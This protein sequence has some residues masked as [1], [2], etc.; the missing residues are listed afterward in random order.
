[1]GILQDRKVGVQKQNLKEITATVFI[2]PYIKKVGNQC[3]NRYLRESKA[4]API[5]SQIWN[6]ISDQF[7]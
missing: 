1:M 6:A 7:H 4:G 5:Q 3:I 2:M